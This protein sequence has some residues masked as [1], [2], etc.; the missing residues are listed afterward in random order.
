MYIYEFL[1]KRESVDQQGAREWYS[2]QYDIMIE[3]KEYA[4]FCCYCLLH[5]TI[6]PFHVHFLSNLPREMLFY[7]C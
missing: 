5:A 2:S 7:F 6:L 3:G 1:A 4:I